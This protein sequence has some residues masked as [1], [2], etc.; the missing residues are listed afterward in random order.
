MKI[1]NNRWQTFFRELKRRKVVQVIIAYVAFAWLIIQVGD[2]LVDTFETP[3][4]FLK[5]LFLTLI[6]GLPV[7]AILAWIFDIKQGGIVKTKELPH[8]NSLD[9]KSI[10]IIFHATFPDNIPSEKCA[11]R[12]RDYILWSE[13]YRAERNE[14]YDNECLILFENSID[15]L[16][17]A[18]KIQN[19]SLSLDLPL[20]ISVIEAPK[21][22]SN[23]FSE[24]EEI[25]RARTL[26]VDAKVGAILSTKAV[27]EAIKNR[28][29]ESVEQAF[30]PI[31]IHRS[32]IEQT[33]Y[34]INPTKIQQ[35]NQA[36]NQYSDTV[37]YVK[38]PMTLKLAALVFLSVI[39]AILWS[40]IPTLE[41]SDNIT[42]SI[43][44][45]KNT[46]VDKNH[47]NFVNG[48]SEDI[49][50]NISKIP[51]LNITSRRSSQAIT[52]SDLSI[53]EIGSILNA[54]WVLEG[55]INRIND[56]IR[57]SIWITDSKSG[58][59]QWNQIFNLSSN[60]L[61]IGNRQILASIS[62][63][64]DKPVDTVAATK[65]S[66]RLDNELYVKYLQAKG[67]LKQPPTMNRLDEVEIIFK[68]ITSK[69]PN[70][71]PAKAGLCK[72]YYLMYSL[73]FKPEQFD[74]AEELCSNVY[75]NQEANIDILIAL[76]MLHTKKGDFQSAANF[77]SIAETIN[78]SDVELIYVSSKLK[79]AQSK[80]K[81]AMTL[82]NQAIDLEPGYWR[83][84]QELGHSYLISG[85][86][87]QAATAFKRVISLIPNDTHGYD[88]LGTSYFF[89]GQ[90]DEAALAYEQSLAIQR[91]EV[92]L[93][94]TAT[95][96]FYHGDYLKASNYYM[97]AVQITPNDYRLWLNLGD[98]VS[99][100]SSSPSETA[101]HYQHALE[102]ALKIIEVNPNNAEARMYIAWCYSQVGNKSLAFEQAEN[103][104]Q[105]SP[106][107]PNIL[108]MAAKVFTAL[109][110]IEQAKSHLK[111]SKQLGFPQSVINASPFI[112]A[113]HLQ[114]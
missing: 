40:F 96:W 88:N 31:D 71:A 29:I 41:R 17:Y 79:K 75:K 70:F 72:A 46:S 10:P 67:I 113:L 87:Q 114:G 7:T 99:Q 35:V 28:G 84:Y 107:D 5:A 63:F 56:N 38:T 6:I 90:F 89:M 108:F 85:N 91:S 44:P 102:L 94:N 53:K 3:N 42:L 64:L 18:I 93:S 111:S 39:G 45:F 104:L 73:Q 57:V 60:D 20:K 50:F 52:N 92:A 30:S 2:V 1:S 43:L 9:I 77:I 24:A 23:N 48:L 62:S 14:V 103:A 15:A 78:P 110:N 83:L 106:N 12:I 8:P 11:E 34:I 54:D 25:V 101:A 68:E 47:D 82:L 19:H 13:D 55:S 105:L 36:L 26:A 100:T 65:V 61:L 58:L 51:N 21:D 109:G 97:Q 27:K 22:Y 95:M 98:S 74:L 112:K 80:S 33:E 66:G 32:A 81:E 4:W 59:E 37:L 69:Q 16:R 49:F 86:W 76:T